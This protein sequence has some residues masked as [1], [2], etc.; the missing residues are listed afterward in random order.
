MAGHAPLILQGTK[1]ALDDIARGEGDDAEIAARAKRLGES[2]DAK[3]G[4]LAW[5]EKR[6]PRYQGR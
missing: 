4:R 3:E 5:L 1:K 2:E 6:P